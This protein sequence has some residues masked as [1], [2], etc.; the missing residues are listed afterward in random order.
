MDDRIKLIKKLQHSSYKAQKKQSTI[1]NNFYSIITIAVVC[2]SI[3]YYTTYVVPAI[4]AKEKREQ[5]KKQHQEYLQ[6]RERR[7][8]LSHKMNSLDQNKTKKREDV[9]K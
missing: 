7:I 3:I 2:V 5:I 6:Q 4:R 8:A 1:I 9:Q